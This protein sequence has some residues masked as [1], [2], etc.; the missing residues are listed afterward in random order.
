MLYHEVTNECVTERELMTSDSVQIGPLN[1][2]CQNQRE[3]VTTVYTWFT[4]W[5]TPSLADS[6]SYLEGTANA[7]P[8]PARAD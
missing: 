8:P 7:V 2:D 6:P 4:Q 1:C 3:M 5:F